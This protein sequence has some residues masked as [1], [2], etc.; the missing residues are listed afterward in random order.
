MNIKESIQI[1][2]ADAVFTAAA[3]GTCEDYGPLRA[4]GLHICTIDEAEQISLT[5]YRHM[6]AE[7]KAALHW[8]ASQDLYKQSTRTPEELPTSR[9]VQIALVEAWVIRERMRRGDPSY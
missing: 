4:M 1:H 3:A 8:E 9:E 2:G 5:V 6:T 7:E